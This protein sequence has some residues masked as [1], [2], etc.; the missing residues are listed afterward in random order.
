MHA[1]PSISPF[2]RAGRRLFL[3][4]EIPNR[5]ATL[6]IASGDRLMRFAISSGDFDCAASSNTR[7]SCL[8][9][10]PPPFSFRA[11]YDFPAFA[12][13]PSSTRRRTSLIMTVIHR[14]CSAL[15]RYLIFDVAELRLEWRQPS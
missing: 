9:D 10:Q 15:L 6:R 8:K 4:R 11:I 3:L 1:E 13:S 14:G 2:A 12:L 7:R 5:I